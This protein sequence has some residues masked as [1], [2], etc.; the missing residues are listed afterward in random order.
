MNKKQNIVLIFLIFMLSFAIV[1]E[2]SA[3]A[4]DD[5]EAGESGLNG[6]DGSFNSAGP[7]IPSERVHEMSD[8]P[9]GDP[10]SNNNQT[11]LNDVSYETDEH[12][13]LYEQ[14]HE[15]SHDSGIQD[16]DNKRDFRQGE[17]MRPDL[18]FDETAAPGFVDNESSEVISDV[19]SELIGMDNISSAFKNDRKGKFNNLPFN[20]VL[21]PENISYDIVKNHFEFKDE[22]DLNHFD[23]DLSFKNTTSNKSNSF[24]THRKDISV[25]KNKSAKIND[26]IPANS[27]LDFLPE[28]NKTQSFENT[29]FPNSN[30]HNR[31]PIWNSINRMKSDLNESDL[32]HEDNFTSKIKE[33][34]KL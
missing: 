33:E 28:I 34:L 11:S 8:G 4:L 14:N 6:P 29:H 17:K 16:I 13:N 2:V 20:G 32:K 21:P 9:V 24:L 12:F 1:S 18:R 10:H 7:H 31:M 27:Q 3:V 5:A 25:F 15:K 23:M 22:G 30:I 26:A 19:T